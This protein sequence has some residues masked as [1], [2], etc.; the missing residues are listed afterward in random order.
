MYWARDFYMQ[1]ALEKH[2]LKEMYDMTKVR[3]LRLAPIGGMAFYRVWEMAPDGT[4]QIN[5]NSRKS[6]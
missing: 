1:K 3:E 5:G 6:C 4:V 2:C